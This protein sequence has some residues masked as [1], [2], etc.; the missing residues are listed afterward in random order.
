[1]TLDHLIVIATTL[2]QGVAW[3][4]ATLGVTPGPGGEHVLMGT[5]NRLLRIASARFPSAYFEII[6]INPIAI[7]ERIQ[8]ARRWFD[9]DH[10]A[11]QA[12]LRQHGPQLAYAVAQVP[13]I[14]A[15]RA[16][17]ALQ[18]VDTGPVI[19]FTRPSAQGPL[20]WQMAV[21]NDGQ[22]L[23]DGALPAPIQWSSHHPGAGMADSG[24]TLQSLSLSHPEPGRLGAALDTAGWAA[25]P[26]GPVLAGAA[27]LS[28]TLA[29]PKGLVTLSSTPLASIACPLR[30]TTP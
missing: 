10:P 25:L 4:E 9:M 8:R 7:T 23:L 22:R 30:N 6:A 12:H 11:L 24:I 2:D 18:G 19:A 27:G 21:R 26:S 3:C 14:A 16:R 5:H 1:M 15:A 28:A 20:A 29:T 13:D 17:L